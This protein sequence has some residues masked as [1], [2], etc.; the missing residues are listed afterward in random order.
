M[1]INR[2]RHLAGLPPK[3]I[4]LNEATN[5]TYEEEHMKEVKQENNFS[6]GKKIAVEWA[7][8]NGVTWGGLADR[9]ESSVPRW[10]QNALKEGDYPKGGTLTYEINKTLFLTH[11]TEDGV[12]KLASQLKRELENNKIEV[13]GLKMGKPQQVSNDIVMYSVVFEFPHRNRPM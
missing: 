1:N 9:P 4:K 13:S 8:R 6:A 5:W 10:L 3:P 2:L 11:H 7:K 12:K